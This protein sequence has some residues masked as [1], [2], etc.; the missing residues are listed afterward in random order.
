[1]GVPYCPFEYVLSIL[2]GPSTETYGQSGWQLAPQDFVLDLEVADL[3]RQLFLGCAGDQQ[4]Q[5]LKEVLH[6]G[7]LTE[8]W[9]T[10]VIYYLHPAESS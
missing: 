5:G 1:M 2:R 6:R 4:Q 8:R 7:R 9:K 10:G 3:P